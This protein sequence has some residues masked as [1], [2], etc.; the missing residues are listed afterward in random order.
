M[1]LIALNI[2]VSNLFSVFNMLLL[3]KFVLFQAVFQLANREVHNDPVLS[4]PS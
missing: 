1:C 4:S 3:L 2:L